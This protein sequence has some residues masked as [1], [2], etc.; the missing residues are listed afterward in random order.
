MVP[1][2]YDKQGNTCFIVAKNGQTTDLT[3]GR[4]S[5]LEAYTCDEFE[6]DSWQAA[7]FNFD[8]GSFSAKGD[9]G[10]LI[11][12]AK[13]KMV[14]FVHSGMPR[15]LSNHVTFGTPAHFVI[16]QIRERFPHAD[17]DRDKF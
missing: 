3:F 7:V 2:S 11:F 4:F 14:A 6:N 12:N 16:E 10:S 8:T 1:Y 13:G 17:F 5:A 15:G 9:S